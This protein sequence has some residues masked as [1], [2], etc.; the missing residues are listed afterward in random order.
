MILV[1]P[2]FINAVQSAYTP[3]TIASASLPV[4]AAVPDWLEALSWMSNNLP[5]SSV[6]FAWW[7]YGYWITVNTGLSTLSDNGTGNTTAIQDIA[8]GFMLN[9][10]LAVQLMRQERVTHVAIFISYN[11]GLCGSNG[12]PLCG[13]GDDSK[14]Y[15]MVRIGNNT[16]INTPL[17]S[18]NV[19]YRQVITNPQTG[20]S[21]YHR[22]VKIGNRTSDERITSNFQNVQIPTSNT[23]LGMLMRSSYPGGRPSDPNDTAVSPH[24]FVQDFASSSSYVL[25]YSVK[26]PDTPSMTAELTPA[27]VPPTGGNT[28]ITGSLTTSTGKPVDTT[29]SKSPVILEYSSNKGSSWNFIANVNATAGHFSYAWTKLLPTG[30]QYV[31]VRARWQGDPAQL[32]DIAVTMPQPLTFM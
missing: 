23:V 18:A 5:H 8:T 22:I 2:T 21:D 29:N 7:D 31:L 6:V 12:P 32:L 25:V 17:G 19:S 13:Y 3:T 15:W 30:Q 28:S 24:F 9:E 16:S 26:Y 4:R 27:I 20:A 1:V 14:W 11:R 10:S